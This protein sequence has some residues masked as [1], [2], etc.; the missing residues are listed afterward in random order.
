MSAYEASVIAL[1]V[2]TF[3]LVRFGVPLLVMWAVRQI[4]VRV[5]PNQT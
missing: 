5:A 2:V 4:A 1:F 3:A